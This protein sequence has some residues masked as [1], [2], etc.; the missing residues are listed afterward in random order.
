MEDKT[1][2]RFNHL[3]RLVLEDGTEGMKQLIEFSEEY[4]LGLN[5][6]FRDRR[7]DKMVL[8]KFDFPLFFNQISNDSKAFK[9]HPVIGLI[10]MM[11]VFYI[12][13]QTWEFIDEGGVLKT[14]KDLH[15]AWPMWFEKDD[16][17]LIEDLHKDLFN[18]VL[19]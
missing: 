18:I 19:Y 11:D 4:I 15:E 16:A 10:F 6:I 17:L 1:E 2:S 9:D 8:E 5:H 14:G 12:T 13:V 7:V 3:K